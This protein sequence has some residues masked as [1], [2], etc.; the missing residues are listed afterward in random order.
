MGKIG[1][2]ILGGFSGKV[3]T[4]I[5]ACLN[6]IEYM[7]SRPRKSSRA[8]TQLQLDVRAKFKLAMAFLKPMLPAI[9][10][11]YQ[12]YRGTTVTPLNAA[13]SDL[14][15]FGLTGMS[16][17]FTVDYSKV[18]YSKGEL[19]EPWT[20]EVESAVSGEVTFNWATPPASILAQPD[21]QLTVI[22]YNPEKGKYVYLSDAA[23]RSALTLDLSLPMNFSGDTVH[24]YLF[25]VSTDGNKVSSS[26]Y[27]GSA[28]LV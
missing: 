19:F 7:R 12:S 17:N 20:P 1:K 10:V 3:G 24:C 9:R 28:L 8:P 26:T 13:V 4:V 16:P 6:G 5:G 23:I 2:G 15:N 21:D 25:F 14:I 27:V 18:I 22:V 11:G